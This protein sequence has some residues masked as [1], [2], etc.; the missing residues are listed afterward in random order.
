MSVDGQGRAT[1]YRCVKPAAHCV[2]GDVALVDNRTGVIIVQHARER[3]HPVGTERFAR[4]GLRRIQVWVYD[5][6]AGAISAASTV[7][8]NTALLY[9]SPDARTL[10]SIP[11]RERPDHILL[12]DGTWRQARAVL[13]ATPWLDALPRFRL[14]PA[15]PSEYR[16]R[17]EPR[18]D[19]LSTIEATVAALRALEPDT[20]GLDGLLDAFRRMIDRQIESSRGSY[21]RRDGRP[22]PQRSPIPRAFT[23]RYE[24]LVVVYGEAAPGVRDDEAA[25]NRVYW[26]AVRPSAGEVFEGFVCPDRAELTAWSAFLRPDDIVAAWNRRCLRGVVPAGTA[27]MVKGIVSSATGRG[28]GRLE[29]FVQRMGLAAVGTAFQGRAGRHMG[30]VLAV[31]E[32]LRQLGSSNQPSR[33]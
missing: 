31:V 12:V 20:P 28:C 2:C 11:E 10:S 23:T 25:G 7:P 6:N 3:H 13:R 24:R 32:Y 21:A 4:L 15:A 14:E 17:R 19:F 30:Q 27:L 1:C 29:D 5:Q 26:C 33:E 9:P 16:V 18:P 22:R 8:P